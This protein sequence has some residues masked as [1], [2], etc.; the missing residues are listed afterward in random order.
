MINILNI[1]QPKTQLTLQ[2]MF[3]SL[4]IPIIAYTDDQKTLPTTSENN[5]QSTTQASN[6]IAASNRSSKAYSSLIANINRAQYTTPIED[7]ITPNPFTVISIG[8][9]GATGNTGML[10]FT[11]TIGTTGTQA[12]TGQTGS[13]SATGNT[14]FAGLTGATGTTGASGP[15]GITGKIGLTGSTAATGSF[16][17]TGTTGNNGLTGSVGQTAITGNFGFTGLTGTVGTTGAIGG[18]G[19]AGA[20]GASGIQRTLIFEN[21]ATQTSASGTTTL[22]DGTTTISGTDP[23]TIQYTTVMFSNG[24]EMF[25]GN[26]IVHGDVLIAGS[27]ILHNSA[28]LTVYG[29]VIGNAK[30]FYLPNADGVSIQGPL[31]VT[32]ELHLNN[33]ETGITV[34]TTGDIQ[35]KYITMNDNIGTLEAVNIAGSLV[36]EKMTLNY[37]TTGDGGRGIYILPSG[38]LTADSIIMSN[39]V[40]GSGVRIDG[41]ITT[42]TILISNSN[43]NGIPSAYGIRMSNAGSITA[44]VVQMHNNNGGGAG[45]GL[46]NSAITANSISM[47]NNIGVENGIFIQ[48]SELTAQ[49]IT[50]AKTIVLSSSG[51]D[52]FAAVYITSGSFLRANKIIFSR[53][54]NEGISHGM[55]S[56][57]NDGFIQTS[58][59]TIEQD[60]S[61]DSPQREGFMV[62][63]GA[64]TNMNGSGNPFLILIT[65]AGC[66]NLGIPPSVIT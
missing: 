6:T 55:F 11:G 22:T 20:T 42:N 25:S 18:L 63:L 62:N 48:T 47:V 43:Y 45:I 21:F 7:L 59:L 37:N 28:S 40:G 26:L 24:L 8:S 17:A 23:L 60:C 46:F 13:I 1:M 2:A 16:G 65:N 5:T 35:A 44:N 57:D 51:S 30:A 38:S 41:N 19:S 14:G 49:N 3:I 27:F 15:T 64:I 12:T 50:I 34:T 54:R 29:N 36:A 56:V 53:N 39:N 61:S 52:S 9:T 31:L 66:T 10:G 32:G 58:I 4:M 33:F